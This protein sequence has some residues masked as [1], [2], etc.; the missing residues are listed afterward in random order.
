MGNHDA[1][2]RTTIEQQ[3]A[4]LQS[5]R[6]VAKDVGEVDPH[7]LARHLKE[8]MAAIERLETRLREA[9]EDF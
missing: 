4:E 7:G 5:W 2:Q 9:A 8:Q 6:E 3:E 1:E